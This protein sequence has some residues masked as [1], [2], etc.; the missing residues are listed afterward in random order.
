MSISLKLAAS[1]HPSVLFLGRTI[2]TLYN[3]KHK[4]CGSKV[5]EEHTIFLPIKA[6]FIGQRDSE[7]LV[8]LQ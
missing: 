2:Y 3:L 4:V 7:S 8:V 5:L 1:E 6:G